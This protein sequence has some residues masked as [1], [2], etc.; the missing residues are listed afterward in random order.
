[1]P[2]K[3][4]ASPRRLEFK[5]FQ[6]WN[7]DHPS[8]TLIFH[9]SSV[10]WIQVE[11]AWSLPKSILKLRYLKRR[12]MFQEFMKA[13]DF[14]QLDLVDDTVT[15]ISLTLAEQSLKPIPIRKVRNDNQTEANFFLSIAHRMSVQIEEDPGRI[16]YPT[17]DQVQDLP[18]FKASDLKDDEVIAPTVST[19][20]FSQKRFAYKKIDRPIYELGDTEHILNE[21]TALAQFRGQQSIAQLIGLVISDNPYNTRPSTISS[22][23]GRALEMLHR[24]RW[25][26]LDIKPSNI[27][28][29]ANKNAILVDISGTGGYEWEWLSPEMQK[30]IE[31]SIATAPATTSPEQ[32]IAT[33][34][35]AYGKLLSMMAR[36]LGAG[37]FGERLRSIG[38]D[39]TKMDPK[40]RISLSDALERI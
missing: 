23:T 19:V 15:R 33:D 20:H 10:W 3:S 29:D 36:K 30:I 17:L 34:C 1:M 28:F 7:G 13:I 24:Q 5:S 32:R 31:R 26:H 16:R 35:W 27:V 40:A 25:T 21:I 9:S 14:D 38:D 18:I 39:L 6:D 8:Q 12:S 37:S 11:I 4:V 22:P 2:P